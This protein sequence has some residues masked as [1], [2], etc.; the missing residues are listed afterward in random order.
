LIELY[1]I[2]VVDYL[3]C[4]ECVMFITMKKIRQQLRNSVILFH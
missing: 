4:A 2:I 3:C 1:D